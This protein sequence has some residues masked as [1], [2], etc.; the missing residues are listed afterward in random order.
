[1][2]P[3]DEDASELS[4]VTAVIPAGGVGTRLWPLS[5]A[6]APKFLHDLTGGGRSLLQATV[7]RLRPLVGDRVVV[8]T[9]AR[10]ADAV[11]AQLPDIAAADLLV[12][13]SPRDSMPA[14]GLAAAVLERRDPDAVLG[15]FAADH[16]IGDLDVF[17]DRVRQAVHVARTGSLVTLGISPTYPA[18]GFGYIRVGDARRVPGAPDAR[19]T[20]AFVEK[21]D[22]QTARRYLET[23]D[24][25]WNAGMFVVRA[26]VLLELLEAA[27]PDMVRELRRIA[28]DPPSIEQRWGSLPRISI[29]HAVA[30]PAARAGRV[31]VVPAPFAW[32]D[33]GDF[34]S[35]ATLLART[36][37]DEALKVL[38]DRRLVVNEGSTGLV[39][40]HGGRTV[41]TLGVDDVVVVDTPDAV[42]VTTRAHCQDVKGVVATLQ[43]LGREDLT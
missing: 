4:D 19:H 42:L 38:G 30:E 26:A 2:A 32:D 23:G 14:V 29:D 17:A 25:L 3:P 10:H 18:T 16:V 20:D 41:V 28:A 31:A 1:M 33:V 21:P 39:A 6:S 37:Q 12:E 5:R 40:A 34:A 35:L 15:S 7:D 43:R 8:V 9:G 36:G 11:R 22:A 24:H 13:P 27:H